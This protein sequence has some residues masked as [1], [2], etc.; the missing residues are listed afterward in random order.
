M[1][2]LGP[3]PHLILI[4]LQINNPGFT[5]IGGPYWNR[6]GS[7]SSRVFPCRP[8]SF[9]QTIVIPLS[10][11]FHFRSPRFLP[12]LYNRQPKCYNSKPEN[13]LNNRLKAYDHY[14]YRCSYVMIVSTVL[15]QLFGHYLRFFKVTNCCLYK[16][17]QNSQYVEN[18]YFEATFLHFCVPCLKYNT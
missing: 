13:K 11:H 14:I 4:R 3:N 16:K 2:A 15:R 6:C 5:G 7:S 10:F 17:I 18:L 9:F 8:L 1:R 12:L